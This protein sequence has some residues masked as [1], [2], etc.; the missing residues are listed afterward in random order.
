MKAIKFEQANKLFTKS[1]DMTDSECTSL[2]VFS[3]NI[4]LISCWEP[5]FKERFAILL[6]QKVWLW[7]H[8]Q[9]QPP[10]ALEIESPFR[11]G[12]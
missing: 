3:D 11:K 6:G 12:G 7:V 10:V 5:S 9:T 1:K 8:G 4:H 2:S